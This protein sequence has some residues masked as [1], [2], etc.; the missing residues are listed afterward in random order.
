MTRKVGVLHLG[1][2]QFS[3]FFGWLVFRPKLIFSS[4][5]FLWE[6][7]FYIN[8]NDK[9]LLLLFFKIFL[10]FDVGVSAPEYLYSS[11]FISCEKKGPIYSFRQP[12]QYPEDGFGTT[13]FKV[14]THKKK[15]TRVDAQLFFFPPHPPEAWSRRSWNLDSRW[16]QRKSE[17]A[18]C[19]SSFSTSSGRFYLYFLL[20]CCFQSRQPFPIWLAE[21]ALTG[22]LLI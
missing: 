16:R 6:I 9:F 19:Q 3:I 4:T 15:K 14:L 7:N 11:I 2:P 21:N 13:S 22:N 1:K 12:I 20:D 5:Q 8:F 10:Y 17:A 18:C